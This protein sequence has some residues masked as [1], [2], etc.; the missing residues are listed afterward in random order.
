MIWQRASIRSFALFA[1]PKA[2]WADAW[3]V[4]VGLLRSGAIKPIVARTFPLAEA[5]DALRYLV[6]GR[7]FGTI[8]LTI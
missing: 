7:P 6:E 3:S 4:I 8:V 2:A 5:A 1:Q